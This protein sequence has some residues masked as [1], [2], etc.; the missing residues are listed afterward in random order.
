MSRRRKTVLTFLAGIAAIAAVAGGYVFY[1]MSRVRPFYAEAI[2]ADPQELKTAGKRMEERVE[3]LAEVAARVGRWETVFTEDEVNGW[4]AYYL[5]DNGAKFLPPQVEDP[6]I[7][8]IDGGA[9]IGF[10]YLGKRLDSVISVEADAFMIAND[11]AAVRLRKAYLGML[12][13][14]IDDVVRH[15]TKG[16]ATLRLPIRW[17]EQEGDP[18]VLLAVADVMSTEQ[19]IRKLEHL[20]LRSGEVVLA[21]R[22]ESRDAPGGVIPVQTSLGQ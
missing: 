3:Q 11:V 4:L 15:I 1:A 20:E 13:I 10:R 18:V 12:P 17:T 21:G 5:E 2:A 8:F 6:R 7:A 22:T 16:A 14:P 9:K 19:E